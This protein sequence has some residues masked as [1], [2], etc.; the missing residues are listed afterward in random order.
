MKANE[1]E[2]VWCERYR[3][4]SVDDVILPSAIKEQLRNIV[5]SLNIGNLLMSGSHGTGKTTAAKAMC[6]ELGLDYIVINASDKRG[7]DV[8]RDDIKDF[9]SKV[10]LTG[11]GKC[12]IL[13]EADYLANTTQ[14][15][16]R[17]AMEGYSKVC[18]FV[19]TC[20]YPNKIMPELHSRCKHIRFEINEADRPKLMKQMLGRTEDIL[21]N[22][23]VEYD[24]KS[25][26]Y[27]IDH[28]FPDNRKIL[29]E[30]DAYAKSGK[31]DEGILNELGNVSIAKLV[32]YM[33]KKDFKQV[34]QWAAENAFNNLETMYTSLY[35]NLDKYLERQS[36]PEAILIIE[37]YMR[38]DAVVADREVHV[39]AL[40]TAMM[41]QLQ[42]K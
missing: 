22:E 4:L 7:L 32:E 20:N 3:P 42:F 13:D 11:K 36:M 21:K 24:R 14:A 9:A 38:Y 40:C 23:G 31:I 15:A 12:V 28:Y 33:K 34:R 19:L 16:L 35:Q 25:L 5:K 39:A 27:V 17:N 6:R 30:L 18:S 1:R 2:I 37:D 10:S 29:N 41:L 26:A 8:I